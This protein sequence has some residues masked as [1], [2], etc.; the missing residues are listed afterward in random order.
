MRNL[1]FGEAMVSIIL[2]IIL[3]PLA[4]MMFHG[5]TDSKPTTQAAVP[6][7]FCEGACTLFNKTACT[8]DHKEAPSYY[9]YTYECSQCGN[10]FTIE[11]VQE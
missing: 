2:A 4:V 1:T 6:C 8:T 10:K 3:I 5:E 11:I 7:E 9:Y